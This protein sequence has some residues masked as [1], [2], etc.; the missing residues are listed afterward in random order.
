[1][2]DDPLFPRLEQFL[3]YFQAI[4]E[5]SPLTIKEYRYDLVLFFA[6]SCVNEN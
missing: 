3:G 2:T 5:R 4:R 6:S 1:M